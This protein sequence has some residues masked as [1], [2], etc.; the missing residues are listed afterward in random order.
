MVPKKDGSWRPCGDYCRLNECTVHDSYPLP[1]LHDSTA[2]LSG[3]MIFSKI[4]LVER[5]HQISVSPQDVLKTA[6]A[7][8]FGLFKFVRMPFGLKKTQPKRSSYSWVW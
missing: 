6:I 1:H 3:A 4:D 5:Y 7:I 8:P 2:R